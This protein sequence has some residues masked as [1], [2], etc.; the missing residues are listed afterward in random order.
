MKQNKLAPLRPLL[1]IFVFLTGFFVASKNMLARWNVD[2]DVLVIG[3]LILLIVT[4]VSYLLLHRGIQSPNPYSFVRAMYVSFIIKFLII[5]LAVFTYIM[6][7]KS[8]VNKPALIAC[9][10]LYLLYTFIEVSV[11][12]KLMK[13]KKNA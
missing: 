5:V 2:Q 11:L 13:K 4:L 10:F 6:I 1:L 8:N 3:N 12:T 9:M 7:A